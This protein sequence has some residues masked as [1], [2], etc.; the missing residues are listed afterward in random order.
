M[1]LV[2][3]LIPTGYMR[4]SPDGHFVFASFAS[5]FLLKLMRPEFA[6]FVSQEQ[7]T[8]IFS[9]IGKLIQVLASSEAS[10]RTMTDW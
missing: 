2:D 8:Q 4:T 6:E 9:L 1:T 3:S 5:A 7:S 10:T